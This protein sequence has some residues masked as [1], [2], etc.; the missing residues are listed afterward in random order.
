MPG[1]KAGDEN[2]E[3][4]QSVMAFS[5]KI[6]IVSDLRILNVAEV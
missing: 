3:V 4:Y 1:G 2:S 6:E 5:Q